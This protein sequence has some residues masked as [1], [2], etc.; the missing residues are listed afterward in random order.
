MVHLDGMRETHDYVTNRK[1]VFDKAVAAIRAGKEQGYHVFPPK[2]WKAPCYLIEGEGYHRDWEEF[3]TKTDWAYWESR[4]D[5]RCQNC[6]MHSGFEHSAV[7]DAMK[8]LHGTL[9]LAVW[10]L[11]V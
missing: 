10:S 3:W 1:G 2:G 5:R 9:K 4:Q 8:T 7:N 6:K 11:G